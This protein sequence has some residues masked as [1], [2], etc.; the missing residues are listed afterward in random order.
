MHHD[1]FP[2]RIHK[3]SLK[4]LMLRSFIV[5][6]WLIIPIWLY[7]IRERG[8]RKLYRVTKLCCDIRS[9]RRPFQLLCFVRIRLLICRQPTYGSTRNHC[10]FLCQ[11]PIRHHITLIPSWSKTSSETLFLKWVSRLLISIINP[12][13]PSKETQVGYVSLSTKG[14]SMRVLPMQLEQFLCCGLIYQD[15]ALH[16]I[17]P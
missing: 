17:I 4:G 3:V 10:P 12:L 6:I 7:P 11:Y 1:R 14:S 5:T 2:C 9:K 15:P 8:G 16:A 13:K